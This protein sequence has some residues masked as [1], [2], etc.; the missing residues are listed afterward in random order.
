MWKQYLKNFSLTLFLASLVLLSGCHN[1]V[2][3]N[4]Q[5]SNT[6]HVTIRH[7][8]QNGI[9]FSHDSGVYEVADLKVHVKAPEGYTIAYTTNGTK[10]SGKN[11]TGK[12]ELDVTLNRGTSGYLL[13]HRQQMFCPA[14]PNAVLFQDNSLPSGIVLNTALV[15]G[16]GIVSDK[17]QSNV[18]FLQ[19]D[20]TKRY[21]NCLIVSVTTDSENLLDYY[22]GILASGAT[23]DEWKETDNVKKLLAE[24]KWW[25]FEINST[26]RGM[27]WERPC[28]IQIYKNDIQSRM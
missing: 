8:V 1:E 12:S 15:D 6:Q 23:F 11:A 22:S 7:V 14:L 2:Q 10:P 3:E 5:N 13:E 21:P 20:F 4:K 27:K 16:K 28:Q 24:N 17:V 18:Y 9:T 26:Q 19:A 25:K